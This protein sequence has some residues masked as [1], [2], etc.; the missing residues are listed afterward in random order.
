MLN[1]KKYIRTD[2]YSLLNIMRLIKSRRMRLTE[3]T[4]R[5]LEVLN[6]YKIILKY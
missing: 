6:T 5:M 2:L 1:L 4:A 3:H